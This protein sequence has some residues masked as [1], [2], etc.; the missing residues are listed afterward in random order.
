MTFCPAG[1]GSINLQLWSDP[2]A[3]QVS[4]SIVIDIM[5]TRSRPL[6]SSLLFRIPFYSD[7]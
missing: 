1:V 2:A 4:G 7:C 6:A 3:L 5:G